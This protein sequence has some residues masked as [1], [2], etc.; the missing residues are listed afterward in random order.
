M[1]VCIW[2][3]AKI[4]IGNGKFAKCVFLDDLGGGLGEAMQ[5]CCEMYASLTSSIQKLM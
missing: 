3:L 4:L 1:F 5:R 2:D